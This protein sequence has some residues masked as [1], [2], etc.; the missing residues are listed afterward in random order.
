M[1]P[2]VPRVLSIAGSDSGGGAGVQADLKTIAAW[3]GYVFVLNM[4]G[5]AYGEHT[6]EL[7]HRTVEAIVRVGCVVACVDYPLQYRFQETIGIIL[8]RRGSPVVEVS[9]LVEAWAPLCQPATHGAAVRHERCRLLAWLLGSVC[10]ACGQAK[11]ALVGD[12]SPDARKAHDLFHG[13]RIPSFC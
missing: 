8:S 11:H 7:L 6:V 9:M 4:I 3:G 5:R 13:D 1:T 12:A 2:A 10:S